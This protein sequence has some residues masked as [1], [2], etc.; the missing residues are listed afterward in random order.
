VVV[1]KDCETEA[2]VPGKAGTAPAGRKG[3]LVG[4]LLGHATI[5]VAGNVGGSDDG[6]T[7]VQV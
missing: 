1:L 6:V 3:V 7:V 2:D 4:G 5:E